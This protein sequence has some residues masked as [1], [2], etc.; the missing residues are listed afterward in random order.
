MT[1]ELRGPTPIL[2]IPRDAFSD[3]IAKLVRACFHGVLHNY[4]AIRCKMGY[5]ADVPV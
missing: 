2:F 4:R 5:R 1:Q 3:S